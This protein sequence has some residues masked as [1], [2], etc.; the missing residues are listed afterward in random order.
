[1]A[2]RVCGEIRMQTL[3]EAWDTA[4]PEKQV[5]L[6]VDGGSENQVFGS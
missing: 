5:E 4:K 3:L 1:M 2:D 6:V